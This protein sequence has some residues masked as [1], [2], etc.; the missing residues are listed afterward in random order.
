MKYPR[1]TATLGERARGE[2]WATGG[3]YVIYT[4]TLPAGVISVSVNHIVRIPHV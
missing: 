4:Y 1:N 2:A 3:V